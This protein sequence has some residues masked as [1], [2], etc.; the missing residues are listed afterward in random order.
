MQSIINHIKGGNKSVGSN[1]TPSDAYHYNDLRKI[2]NSEVISQAPKRNSEI[3]NPYKRGG[4]NLGPDAYVWH[5]DPAVRS[6]WY[7]QQGDRK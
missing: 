5:P 3:F 6:S 7:R 2:E 1:P 4:Y